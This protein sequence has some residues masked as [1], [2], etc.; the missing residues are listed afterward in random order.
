MT[1]KIKIENDSKVNELL[2]SKEA[3]CFTCS[4]PLKRVEANPF[5]MMF[6]TVASPMYCENDECDHFGM[7]TLGFSYKVGTKKVKNNKKNE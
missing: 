6:G 1:E 7:L 2:E 5:A 3:L 4:E